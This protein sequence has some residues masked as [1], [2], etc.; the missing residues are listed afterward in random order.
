MRRTLFL[1][2][3]IAAWLLVGAPLRA[4]DLVLER[5]RE[6]LDALRTQA[7][8]PGLSATI[9]GTNDIVWEAAYGKQDLER[10][11]ATRPGT[12]FH[13]DGLTQTFTAT[14]VLGCVETSRLS[15]DERIGQRV[16]DAPEPNATI[17]QLLS[18]TSDDGT[19]RYRLDRLNPLAA[20]VP[21]CMRDS[22]RTGLAKLFDQ[23]A[24]IDSVPGPDVVQ[25]SPDG[26]FTGPALERYGKVL[27]G[28]ATPYSVDSR[29]QPSPS[30]YTASTLLAST[31]V[32]STTRDLAQFLRGLMTGV[33]LGLNI[34]SLAWKPA[35]GANGQ[36]LPHGL[37]WFVQR[38]NGETVAWQFGVSDNA[39]SSLMVSVPGRGLSL[40]LL[41]NS[42]GLSRSLPLANG[43]LTVSP[44]GRL[45]LGS[46]VR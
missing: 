40:V 8:I 13:L 5:F 38:Y 23:L 15:L 4:Q 32:V 25:L 28:L 12:P 1:L 36:P 35:V 34:T 26:V 14:L 9:V 20:V 11:I 30:R 24:M 16:P 10:S 29:G 31:G 17:R 39:S 45:F 21:A 37:G 44:F 41:A 33:G 7:G 18:H 19:F 42:D 27:G 3:A 22:F 6:A 2:T 43:D 46:F